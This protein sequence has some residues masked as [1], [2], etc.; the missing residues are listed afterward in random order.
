MPG[1]D[2]DAG[3]ARA[4]PRER[5]PG[6]PASRP[7]RR[8]P[9]APRTA[10]GAPSRFRSGG[11]R[12]GGRFAVPRAADASLSRGAPRAPASPW[13]RPPGPRP[14][15]RPPGPRPP[16]P[17]AA[18]AAGALAAER[19][20]SGRSRDAA[21]DATNPREPA[22]RASRSRASA[23]RG[24]GRRARA[25]DRLRARRARRRAEREAKRGD[26]RP[27]HPGGPTRADAARATQEVRD[28]GA[29]GG[30]GEDGTRRRET[31]RSHHRCRT[32]SRFENGNDRVR[33]SSV[34]VK[35]L[36][37]RDEPA[38][39]RRR[40][41]PS[42]RRRLSSDARARRRPIPAKN[43]YDFQNSTP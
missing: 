27:T 33:R 15:P 7:P 10:R 30:S 37:D 1:G 39:R 13:P 6:A 28:G 31:R 8:P 21:R 25:G 26:R 2:S 34:P 5:A 4:S 17:V 32:E 40:A 24:L 18:F 42:R 35:T 11:G 22:R 12:F 3:P 19:A 9:P 23:T 16:P 29:L 36:I 20:R 43:D 38:A 14:P 41:P